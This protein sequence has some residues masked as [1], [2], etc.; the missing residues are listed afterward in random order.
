[1]KDY[2]LSDFLETEAVQ[3]IVMDVICYFQKQL[4][5]HIEVRTYRIAK[6][7]LGET[8]SHF[9]YFMYLHH[10]FGSNLTN[11][12]IKFRFLGYRLD[13]ETLNVINEAK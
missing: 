2:D 8:P 9:I 3:R 5:R 4:E 13:R 10:M 7:I 6:R 12:F 11:A 1:M